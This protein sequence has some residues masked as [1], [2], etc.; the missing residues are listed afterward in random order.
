MK[1]SRL[2]MQNRSGL[3]RGKRVVKDEEEKKVEKDGNR[4][5]S[6]PNEVF[7]GVELKGSVRKIGGEER[8]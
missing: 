2:Q 8:Q 4:A 6:K 7:G 3:P 1:M 5:R